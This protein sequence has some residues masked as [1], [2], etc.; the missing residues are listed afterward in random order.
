MN[1]GKKAVVL[2]CFSCDSWADLSTTPPIMRATRLSSCVRRS[3]SPYVFDRDGRCGGS[4]RR[5][6]FRV[7]TTPPKKRAPLL[8]RRGVCER[9]CGRIF[10]GTIQFVDHLEVQTGRIRRQNASIRP[11]TNTKTSFCRKHAGHT[12]KRGLNALFSM[13]SV[14]RFSPGTRAGHA[15]TGERMRDKG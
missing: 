10:T 7:S 11:Q 2:S 14:S 5:G 15:G 9:G 6:V 3:G 1:S 13:T 4:V 8:S 12:K